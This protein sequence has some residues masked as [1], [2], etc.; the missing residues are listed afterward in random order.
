LLGTGI[1]IDSTTTPGKIT[2]IS[3]HKVSSSNTDNTFGFLVDKLNGSTSNGITI[4][5][6]YNSIT[7]R[8][9]LKLS[10]DSSILCS[11]LSNCINVCASYLVTPASSSLL[12]YL[13]CDGEVV[14]LTIAGATTICARVGSV[15]APA[16]T[17]VNQG[18]C[19]SIV[20]NC[21]VLSTQSETITVLPA[22]GF[23]YTRATLPSIA[24]SAVTINIYLL[25]T[26]GGYN[27]SVVVPAGATQ[28]NLSLVSYTLGV[29]GEAFVTQS[30]SIT[31]PISDSNFIYYC[32][33]P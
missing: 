23:I 31:S 21:P 12:N 6:I 5:P 4:N 14:S 28:S 2:L 27:T 20:T 29:N 30:V 10:V 13:N 3:D 17:I 24:T 33:Q 22:I 15:Y 32:G 9:D 7:K 11:L 26:A 1:V 25:T 19:A 16:A 18:A 8:V